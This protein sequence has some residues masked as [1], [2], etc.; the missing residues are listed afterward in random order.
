[1]EKITALKIGFK[2]PY[3]F[4]LLFVCL[5]YLACK[6][7]VPEVK[8]IG[9]SSQEHNNFRPYLDKE[10]DFR[11]NNGQIYRSIRFLPDDVKTM[12]DYYG[13]G[14]TIRVLKYFYKD[15]QNGKTSVYY[16]N[17]KLKEVQHYQNGVQYKGDTIF[18]ESGKIHFIYNFVD[19]K[20]NGWM[21]RYNESG[22]QEYAVLYEGDTIK[23]VV[24]SLLNNRNE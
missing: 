18:Y 4:V 20:K 5:C 13:D 22:D 7:N 10:Q 2:L 14:K 8:T 12:T 1:M 17:G 6:E 24:D 16:P 21:Y 15:L 11:N 3:T 9:S 23:Q 19:S